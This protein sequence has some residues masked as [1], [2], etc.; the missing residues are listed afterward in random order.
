MAVPS[1]AL[2]IRRIGPEDGASL[3]ALAETDN[4]F[5]E[6]PAVA[7]SGAL[8]P[9]GARDFLSDPTVLFWLAEAENRTVGFLHCCVQ[10]RRTA[11]PWAELLLM[12]MG[13]HAEYRRQGIGRALIC[14]MEDWMRANG[15]R[16]VWVPAN[17]SAVGF[18][19]KCGFATDE[20]EI[21]VKEL[22]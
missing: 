3:N 10:R 21:L 6:D 18:Y 4:L 17:T 16:D 20:G 22:H 5:D 15:V 14:A 19:R 12:E 11:G 1:A 7:P 2:S 13:T 8:T 9:D